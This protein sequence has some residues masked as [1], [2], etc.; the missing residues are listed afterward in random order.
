MKMY[1]YISDHCSSSEL[2]DSAQNILHHSLCATQFQYLKPEYNINCVETV[3][4]V[5]VIWH[6]LKT[7]MYNIECF[8][9]IWDS[10]IS[11]ILN[12]LAYN[13][14]KMSWVLQSKH[15]FYPFA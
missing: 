13:K 5:Y 10:G 6:I 9:W 1:H 2:S 11:C 8:V 15:I 12:L 14:Y 4:K 3:C 7:V